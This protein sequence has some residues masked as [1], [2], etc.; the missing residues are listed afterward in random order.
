MDDVTLSL[1]MAESDAVVKVIQD[2]LQLREHVDQQLEKCVT[3]LQGPCSQ[4]ALPV[5]VES[6]SVVQ[7]PSIQLPLKRPFEE[8]EGSE[9]SVEA[10]GQD[11]DSL[12]C[13]VD[14]SVLAQFFLKGDL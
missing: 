11:T 4:N 9:A 6:V 10:S 14:L 8:I 3:Q 13:R 5:E 1:R 7:T 12:P 2:L